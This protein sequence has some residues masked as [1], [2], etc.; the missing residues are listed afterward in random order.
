MGPQMGMDPG[1]MQ[2]HMAAIPPE[3]ASLTN[4]VP[5]DADSLERGQDIYQANC[6]TCHGDEGWGDGP[7]AANLDPSP[8]PLAHTA[9]MLSDAYLFYRLS[10]GGQ[11]PPFNSAMPAW[12]ERLDEQARW[13]VINYIRSLGQNGMMPGDTGNGDSSMMDSMMAPWWILGWLL[14][15]V[16]VVALVLAAVW[17]VGRSRTTNQTPG[18]PLTI[19]KRRYAQGEIDTAQFEDMKRRLT[20]DEDD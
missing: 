14:V 2:R 15:I 20:K 3:Y 19:L 4:P 9:P 10:E 17:A 6:A 1:M 7:A 11:F 12:E 13:D 8:A 18:T 16:L 5:A